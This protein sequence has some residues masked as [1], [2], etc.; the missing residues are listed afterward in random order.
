MKGRAN[1]KQKFPKAPQRRPRHAGRTIQ[2][3]GGTPGRKKKM[4]KN[5]RPRK[6]RPGD[7]FVNPAEQCSQ[8][9]TAT[10]GDESPKTAEK[11]GEDRKRTM[12]IRKKGTRWKKGGE[13][14]NP[15]KLCGKSVSRINTR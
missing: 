7:L 4:K 3:S 15:K 12:M 10:S 11:G 8:K 1:E 9:T 14:E 6:V 2:T 5:E 13:L